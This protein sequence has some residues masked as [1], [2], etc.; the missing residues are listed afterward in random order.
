MKTDKKQDLLEITIQDKYGKGELAATA[1]VIEYDAGH[2]RAFEVDMSQADALADMARIPEGTIRW[3]NADG[4]Y[5][6]ELL[7][8]L[9]DAFHIHPLVIRNV[10]NTD[11]RAKV[12]VYP[13][14][15]HIV[16]KMIYF[17]GDT[18]VVEH[19]NFLLGRNFVI[20]LGET[21]GDVFDNIRGWINSEGAHV[22]INGAD[23][24]MYLLLDAIVEGYFDVLETLNQKTDDLEELVMADTAQEHLHAIR[25]IKKALL[26]VNK[27]IWPLRDVASLMRNETVGLIRMTTEPYLRD[28][29]NH[30]VQAIDSTETSRELLSSLTDLHISNVSYKLNEIM[31]VLTI[32]STLFIPLT[33]VAGVYGMN[34]RYMPELGQKWGYPLVWLV[35]III[36]AGMMYFF[37]K[38][39]WF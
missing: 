10:T 34:F 33:F 17:R 39:K 5:P 7:E 24:L 35:M 25:E 37:K 20:T 28:V 32:I 19:I 22:R 18:L 13:D 15:L 38:K 26:K 4:Q 1:D 8:K 23:Y 16:A 30:I 31:K 14:F 21:K 9:G 12:D 29:Y 3:I 11:Q 2:S 6:Q 27:C 36:A